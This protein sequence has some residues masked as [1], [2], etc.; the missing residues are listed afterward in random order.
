MPKGKVRI[1]IVS[2]GALPS[3]PKLYGGMERIAY[4][5]AEE[6]VRRGHEVTLF[7]KEGSYCSGRTVHYTEMGNAAQNALMVL[8]L[9]HEIDIFHSITHAHAIAEV[10]PQ[11]KFLLSVRV[12]A[13]PSVK[14]NM[15]FI[16]KAQRD[17]LK[18]GS[19]MP[20]VHNFVPIDEYQYNPEGRSYLLYLGAILPYKGVDI[21]IEV[22]K[23]AGVYLK[24]AGL[25][26]DMKYWDTCIRE[27]V[28]GKLPTERHIGHQIEYYGP[29]GGQEKMDLLKNAL[30]LIHPVRWCESGATVVLEAL[31]CGTPVIGSMNGAL[32]ELVRHGKTGYLFN[33]EPSFGGIHLSRDNFVDC[34]KYIKK[35]IDRAKC[36]E[37][38]KSFDV[39]I[40]ADKYLAL[41]KKVLRGE[42]W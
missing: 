4:W 32:P 29:V 11:D 42:G 8:S 5:L 17:Y 16:S 41:Y 36:R 31:A 25:C 23:K 18:L 10:L 13:L 20:V 19:D 7:G 1:G 2:T 28:G 6:F 35:E 27:N 33:V 34:V 22:A 40:A 39:S 12:L 21:A 37:A 30:A 26:R 3:P 24:I 14:R 38:A 15:T 9:S